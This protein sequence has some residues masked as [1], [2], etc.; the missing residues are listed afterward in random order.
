MG[1]AAEGAGE[2]FGAAGGFSAA[3]RERGR[4]SSAPR[5][6]ELRRAGA[7]A[8]FAAISDMGGTSCAFAVGPLPSGTERGVVA[9]GTGVVGDSRQTVASSSGATVSGAQAA[10]HF[11]TATLRCSAMPK[12]KR[13]RAWEAAAGEPAS[14]GDPAGAGDPASADCP[15]G[16]GGPAS[17][18]CP[19]GVG[20]PAGA[21]G[22]TAAGGPSIAGGAA[23]APTEPRLLQ[24]P[25]LG[26]GMT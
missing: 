7:L 16:T 15:A 11:P 18:G 1:E 22:L 3:R 2:A 21:G 14:A 25:L 19:A 5:P 4:T 10:L 8:S 23:T 26:L 12:S 24:R 20:G 13:L 6:R 17:A 9:K